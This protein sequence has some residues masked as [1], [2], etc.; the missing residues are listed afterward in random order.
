MAIG[1]GGLQDEE[2]RGALHYAVA[3]D[4]PDAVQALLAA[5]AA[6]EVADQGGNTPLHY[7][8]GCGAGWSAG[9]EV[10]KGDNIGDSIGP[11]RMLI[12]ALNWQLHAFLPAYH[13][14]RRYGREECVLMLLGAGA[15]VGATTA[16]GLTPAAVI[17]AEPRNPLNQNPGLLAVLEGTAELASIL[18]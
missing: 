17:R 16:K 10:G 5:G 15:D 6:L 9:G 4:H 3:Y 7:A 12:C 2:Q 14:V 1:K 8:A 13:L 18:A 11:S